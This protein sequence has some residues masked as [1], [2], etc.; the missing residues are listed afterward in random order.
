MKNI[1]IACW[2]VNGIRAVTQ[3]GLNDW[4]SESKYHIY[5]F[6]EIKAKENQFP[7]EILESKKMNWKIHPAKRPGYSG[8]ASLI[9]NRL[10][11][12]SYENLGISKFDDEGRIQVMEFENFYLIN[13]YI[14][15]GSRDHS[16]VDFKLK[17]SEEVLK[18]AKKLNKK[19][20][21][22]LC[23]DFN[24]AHTELDLKNPKTNHKTTG[25]LPRERAWM[26]KFISEG[27]V[28][29]FREKHIDEPDHYT[30]WS[31]RNNCRSRNIGW[32]IDYF[33]ATEDLLPHIKKPEILSDVM[34]SDH[35]PI[36]LELKF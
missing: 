17:C 29:V 3:K 13:C 18:K 22:L 4:F 7:E 36:Y 23:G 31:Y 9:S 5:C 14:P 26:D 20:P 35:C 27:F 15:N 8:V 1:K 33:F 34:G 10:D 6:Q 19:K 25:F 16:R 30:W 11:L 2:N 32:R 21:V 12:L 28:D 24:T